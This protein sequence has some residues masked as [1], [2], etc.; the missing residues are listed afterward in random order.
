MYRQRND[1]QWIARRENVTQPI[2]H[3][4]LLAIKYAKAATYDAV[5]CHE[6]QAPDQKE[7]SPVAAGWDPKIF[8]GC[9]DFQCTITRKGSWNAKTAHQSTK[10]GLIPIKEMII[11]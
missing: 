7:A 11:K 8:C 4:R 6:K 3:Y 2:Q 1:I 10:E 5:S 9:T